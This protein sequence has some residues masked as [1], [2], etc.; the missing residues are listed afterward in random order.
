MGWKKIYICFGWNL[1]R[2]YQRSPQQNK[3][4]KQ[5]LLDFRKVQHQLFLPATSPFHQGLY[6]KTTN[7]EHQ[8][9]VGAEVLCSKKQL[10]EKLR[11]ILAKLHQKV[12]IPSPKMFSQIYPSIKPFL[13]LFIRELGKFTSCRQSK[14]FSEKLEKT[15][16]R[17]FHFKGSPVI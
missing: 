16:K 1:R 2:N 10:L 8:Q 7:Q 15:D 13:Y 9:V 17:S 12:K 6:P 5:Y 11:A 4:P 3:S 14:V